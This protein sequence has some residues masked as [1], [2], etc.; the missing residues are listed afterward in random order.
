MTPKTALEHEGIEQSITE[1]ALD[2]GITPGI[3][4]ARLER[5]QSTADAITM[6]MQVGHRG[7]RLPIFSMRQEAQVRRIRTSTGVGVLYLY[8]GKALT[9]REWSNH[10]GLKVNT[11]RAR[12]ADGWSI[13]RALSAPLDRRGRRR[14]VSPDFTPS[15]GTGAGSTAQETPNITFQEFTHDGC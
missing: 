4:M 3:I 13:N 10:T 8:D 5:G 11:I 6:P 9:L 1:W 7:Q 2:Y 14:G 15:A 12:L